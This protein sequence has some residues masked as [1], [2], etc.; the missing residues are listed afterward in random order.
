MQQALADRPRSAPRK[1]R[2]FLV[3]DDPD[4]VD[5]LRELL[6]MEGHRVGTALHT[7]DALRDIPDFGPDVVLCDLNVDEKM[8]GLDLV[9][10]LRNDPRLER[11]VFWAV[12]GL[13]PSECR[14]AALEAGFED[15]LPKPLD[16]DALSEKLGSRVAR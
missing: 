2:I 15:V 7:S 8:S 12:T 1:L 14:A 16:F 4:V 13:A 5:A 3:D 6:L 11:A 9:T 10:Q